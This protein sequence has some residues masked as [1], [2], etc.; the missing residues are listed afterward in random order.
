MDTDV[1][2]NIVVTLRNIGANA[3]TTVEALAGLLKD[4]NADVRAQSAI[5]LGAIGPEARSIIPALKASTPE[6]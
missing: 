4:P 6:A 2:L 1:R 5:A 3:A